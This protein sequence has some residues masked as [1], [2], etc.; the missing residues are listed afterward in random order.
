[1]KKTYKSD[2][3]AAIHETVSD[4]HDIGLASTSTMRSFD[5]S[6]LTPITKLT[7]TEIKSIRKK[8]NASQAV[9]A[10]Y[11]NVTTLAVSQWEAGTRSPSGAALKL[12]NLIKEKGLEAIA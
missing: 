7:A 9:L 11:M 2:A 4:L 12:L 6:C 10:R 5:E 8:S 3:F 1:M